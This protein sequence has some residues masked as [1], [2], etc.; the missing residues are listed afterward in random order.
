MSTSPG[1]PHPV[2]VDDEI[3]VPWTG[4]G[5][6]PALLDVRN[7]GIMAHID[8]GKTTTTERILFYS[9]RIH[10]MGEVHEGETTM[11]YMKEERE[12]GIT[13][14]SAATQTWWKGCK[15]N[16]I[17][18]PGH[19]DFTAEVER[20]LRV[21]DGAVCVFDAK[22]GVEP[23]SETVW[24]QANRYKVPRICFLNKMD[25]PGADFEM[26]IEGIRKRLGANAIPVQ[27][28]IGQGG[29]FRGIVDIVQEVAI[30]YDA[31]SEGRRWHEAPVPDELKPR[32]EALRRELV[33]ACA[34]QDETLMER[35]FAGEHLHRNDLLVAMRKGVVT[36]KINPVLVG[37]ALRNKGVQRLIDAVCYYLPSP[38]DISTVRGW[39][40]VTKE[41]QTRKVDSKDPLSALAFKIISDKNGDLTFVRVYSGTLASGDLVW[42]PVRNDRERISRIV[43]MH[44]NEREPVEKLEAGEIGA[45][46]GLK[47]TSTGD[48]LC[49]KD[50]P[51]VLESMQFPPTVISMS[52]RPASR[53]DRDKLSD[54]L[55]KLA[56]EDPTFKRFTDP[57]TGETIIAG[58]GELHLDIIKSRLVNE[59]GIHSEVGK[60]KV[61]YRQTFRKDVD[62]E[63]KHVKQS[64]GRGQFGIV[65]V[66]FKVKETP[67]FEFID[68]I[69]GG[70]V[71]REY[72]KPVGEGLEKALEEGYPLGF[73]FM[74]VSG[75]LYD[76]KSHEV[77]SSE[78]AFME[79]A[80][81]AVRAATEMVGVTILEP[82]MKVSVT[83]P[84]TN[85]GDVMG[86]INARRGV[87]LST[88]QGSG[89]TKQVIAE[90]PLA[91]MFQ[92]STF[93]RGM[94]QG[95]GNYTME[96][97]KYAPAPES[98][99]VKIRK[100][101]EDEK[102][103]G[104]K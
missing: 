50:E 22:E 54:A 64:G 52:I 65:R 91:E 100:E 68:S 1:T 2:S 18:T 75:E 49:P 99:A 44:A 13:I 59:Y 8:A 5:K 83:T 87:V 19:V 95:R 84:E 38:I 21:L 77:D 74:N 70:S 14:T 63:G 89:D 97:C 47:V 69:V 11:D 79:A 4:S 27:Y 71:P 33:E 98:V 58:M 25:K 12:R 103:A 7:F 28:P 60:P 96:P 101:I 56:K 36:G 31:E 29:E 30:F 80:R 73:P 15:L 48:T 23:Q 51:I 90:V 55:G 76:G 66:K 43:L 41:E 24:R 67:E 37:S 42:N 9:G 92:Y 32:I 104:R 10:K 20:S 93:L 81:L 34:E 53:G 62:A 40:P 88:E 17:D 102:K 85:L 72:I 26:C 39:H 94:T 61:A 82:I 46:I 16:I 6:R 3:L 35:Y 57:E 86:S 78:M 45:V